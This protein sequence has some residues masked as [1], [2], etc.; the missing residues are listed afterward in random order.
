MKRIALTL[1]GILAAGA[2]LAPA[3]P[4][5][6]ADAAYVFVC[7]AD[8]YDP[9]LAHSPFTIETEADDDALA[10][11][12]VRPFPNSPVGCSAYDGV[13]LDPDHESLYPG[14][15]DLSRQAIAIRACRTYADGLQSLASDLSMRLDIRTRERDAALYRAAEQRRTIRSQAATIRRLRARLAAR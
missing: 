2:T 3:A 14:D 11:M 10:G 4:A 5:A 6:A 15:R 1:A 8:P 12:I 9:A 7:V 13:P